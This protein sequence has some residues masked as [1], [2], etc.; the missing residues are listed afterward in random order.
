MEAIGVPGGAIR[1]S[2]GLASTIE[3]VGRFLTL[4]ETTYRDQLPSGDRGDLRATSPP[5]RGGAS[6]LSEAPVL[7]LAGRDVAD[8]A[9]RAG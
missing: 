3:D 8:G 1:A 9:E 5:E 6:R 2:V 7:G 4:L